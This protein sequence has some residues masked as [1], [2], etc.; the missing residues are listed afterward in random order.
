MGVRFAG[1]G[2]AQLRISNYPPSVQWARR[3]IWFPLKNL[4]VWGIG[5]PF[6]IFAVLGMLWMAW[7]IVKGKWQKYT[8]LWVWT[9]VYIVWQAIRWNPTMRYFLLVYPTLAIIAAWCL[10]KLIRKIDGAFFFKTKPALKFG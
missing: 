10:S 3:S 9:L 7:K 4:T 2:S 1:T 8:M 6:A 5:L